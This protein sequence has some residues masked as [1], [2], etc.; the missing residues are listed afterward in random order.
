MKYTASAF[1]IILEKSHQSNPSNPLITT[2]WLLFVRVILCF[3]IFYYPNHGNKS[4][5]RN[6]HHCFLKPKWTAHKHDEALR[7]YSVEK[8]SAQQVAQTFGSSYRALTSLVSDFKKELQ[9]EL[10]NERTHEGW[11]FVQKPRGR[12]VSKSVPDVVQQIVA[13]RKLMT[14]A[15]DSLPLVFKTKELLSV[16][17]QTISMEQ[18]QDLY[19]KMLF[20]GIVDINESGLC[21]VPIPSLKYH[22]SLTY[23]NH[24]KVLPTSIIIEKS[25]IPE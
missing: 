9:K 11:F 17:S 13:F 18:A 16:L 1:H 15:I 2:I 5:N 20:K 22:L 25:V 7:M 23:G 3:V 21:S 19:N 12:P 6:I 14:S 8:A 24:E 10:P 4:R